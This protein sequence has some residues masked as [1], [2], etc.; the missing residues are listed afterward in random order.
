MGKS[1]ITF[2]GTGVMGAS[3]IKHLLNNDYEVTIYTRTKT[4]PSR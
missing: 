1:K 2:I 3:V 4:K